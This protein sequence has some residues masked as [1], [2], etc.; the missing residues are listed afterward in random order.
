M[1]T[2]H[3]CEHCQLPI[4]AHQLVTVSIEGQLR[5]FCC[6][7]CQGAYQL[8][9]GAGLEQFY[10]RRSWGEAGTAKGAYDTSFNPEFLE[11]LVHQSE[12]GHEL[13]FLIEGIRCASCV[14]LNEKILLGLPGVSDTRINYGTHRA[15]VRFDPQQITP[16]EIFSRITQLGYRPRPMT[17]KALQDSGIR[18]RRTLLIRFGTAV[19]LS[20]QLMGYSLALYAGYFQG[21]DPAAR[22]LIQY[23]AAGVSTPVV[24]YA[25]WPFLSGAW[26]S[27]RNRAPNMDLLIALGVL[28]AYC[29]S[30]L[31]LATGGEIYFDSA[32]M[33]VTLILLGRLLE[34]T[35][36]RQAAAGIDRLLQLAPDR[37]IRLDPSGGQEVVE[38]GLLQPGDLILVGPGERFAAD[39]ALTEGETEVDESIVTGEPL[40]VHRSAGDKITSGSLNISTSVTL[41]VATSAS[42]S[43]IAK[44]ARLVEEA[45]ARRAPA[46]ALADRVSAWFVPTVILLALGTFGFWL[47]TDATT[48]VAILNATAVLVVACPCALG[49]A[50]PTAIL[51]ATGAATKSGILFRG[52]DILEQTARLDTIAF[53]KTGTLTEGA[54]TVS[55][56]LPHGISSDELLSLAARLESGTRHPIAAGIQ[57]EANRRGL[58]TPFQSGVKTIPGRGLQL[59][60]PGE[61]LLAGHREFIH[62]AGIEVP[63][64]ESI[65]L[66]EVHL[67]RN[68]VYLGAILLV[69][70]IRPEA[71]AALDILHAEHYCTSLLTGDPSAAGD[72]VTAELGIGSL[73]TALTPEKKADWI[74]A[75]QH[76]GHLVMMV[77]DGINDAPALAAADVGCAMAGGTD[78]ALESSDIILTRPDLGKLTEAV[79]LA[80]RT[81]RIIKENLFWAFTYNLV[82]IPL[83][84]SGKLAP[85]YAA[86]AMAASSVLVVGNSLRLNLTSGPAKL[87]QAQMKRPEDA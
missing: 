13:A 84:A 55:R 1:T 46:Q 28:T 82:A 80:K 47:Q 10:Q 33:I 87:S 31:M 11:S 70:R 66:T 85:A 24:F 64:L 36:R 30:L 68:Q 52:G 9:S 51:V 39:G 73:A 27:M 61:T 25:G 20:M 69:D 45:Q 63:P 42:E 21:I 3:L 41:R 81:L 7:G 65:A 77:G 37:S 38:T 43:F 62:Q 83:A 50:T 12:Q 14:W 6:R 79:T 54:P 49:L 48:G 67:A 35:A 59:D 5:H 2:A 34:S 76:M 16:L 58:T 40:P 4:D 57:R 29:Y 60:L 23:F 72:R 32:A 74:H 78:I 22:Q 19:F 86:A 44:V 26:R 53:D 17:A 8:I 75:R 71:K 18:E 56:I 15:R